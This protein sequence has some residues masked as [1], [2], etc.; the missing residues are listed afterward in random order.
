MDLKQK[1]REAAELVASSYLYICLIFAFIVLLKVLNWI[2]L[3]TIVIKRYIY[4]LP[5]A[6]I[7]VILALKKETLIPKPL[8][9]KLVFLLLGTLFLLVLI[10]R[11]S[12]YLDN[13]IP[14]GYDAGFYKYM[15]EKYNNALPQIPEESLD[16]WIKKG[17]EQGLF[18]VS[19]QLFIFSGLNAVE[20][21]NYLFPFLCAFLVFPIFLLAKTVFDDKT[22]VLAALFYAVSYTQYAMFSFL[23]LKT[24]FGLMFLLLSLY[25][26]QK[27]KYALFTLMYAALGI[28]HAPEFLILSL[29]LV[30]Y[31]IFFKRDKKLVASVVVALFLIAPFWLPRLNYMLD[32][33]SSVAGTFSTNLSTGAGLG[34]GTFFDLTE[35]EWVSIVYLPFALAGALYLLLKKK[36]N[37]LF[38]CFIILY[39]IVFFQLFFFKRYIIVFDLFAM[40]LAAGAVAYT[41]FKPSGAGYAKVLGVVVVSLLCLS[42]AV[43]LFTQI[44]RVTPL[45]NENQLASI[46]WLAENTEPNAFVLATSFDAPWVLGWSERRVIA[47]GL[48]DWNKQGEAEWLEFLKTPDYDVA[49]KLLD[50]YDK[51][52][53]VYYSK[54]KWNY[55]NL[56]K[57][58]NSCFKKLLNGDALV[59]QYVC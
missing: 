47:P 40:I 34:G 21:F 43:V 17:N 3:L 48:F 16:A 12:P 44:P 10:P 52:I 38:L 35:Y 6:A 25:A 59:Y 56:E 58:E 1:T 5:L 53:Y 29:A 23:Y 27:E 22:G 2:P 46:N 54:S 20:I 51:P 39:A 49:K 42:S 14:I 13:S 50:V 32:L 4:F 9:K 33:G 7:P 11:I 55:L 28:F 15:I 41:L 24:I 31:F 26:L 19:S 37:P 57:F 18:F 30:P 36:W 8:S 45:I